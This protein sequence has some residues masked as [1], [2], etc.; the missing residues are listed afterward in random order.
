MLCTGITS[1]RS[2][3]FTLVEM[4][5][6]ISMIALML[7]VSASGAVRE[8]LAA[9][10]ISDAIDQGRTIASIIKPFRQ[11]IV[12]DSPSTFYVGYSKKLGSFLN[13]L[14]VDALCQSLK[15]GL[16]SSVSPSEDILGST[17]AN[18]YRVEIRQNAVFVTLAADLSYQ[19]FD[20]YSAVKNVG[21]SAV[22]WTV[23]DTRDSVTDVQ[24]TQLARINGKR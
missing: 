17:A 24:L 19:D 12:D 14:N 15:D 22:S 9:Q 13:D 7:V 16:L 2:A 10:R 8:Q 6:V 3:G 21:V 23:S 11:Q 4:M 18:A 1:R 5:V 20:F